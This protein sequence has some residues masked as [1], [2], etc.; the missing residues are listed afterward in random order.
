MRHTRLLASISMLLATAACGLS[1]SEE[2]ATAPP[3]EQPG[4]TLP[5]A[6][7]LISTQGGGSPVVTVG[8]TIWWID[9]KGFVVGGPL[10]QVVFATDS[11]VPS[12]GPSTPSQ[13]KVRQAD[14]LVAAGGKL[15]LIDLTEARAYDPQ[16][17]LQNPQAEPTNTIV[18]APA[19]DDRFVYGIPAIAAVGSLWILILSNDGARQ[20]LLR[21]DPGSADVVARIAI[22]STNLGGLSD[23]LVAG[24]THVYV[25]TGSTILAVD[26]ATNTITARTNNDRLG[27]SPNDFAPPRIQ[28]AAV[29]G[30]ELLVFI[31][32]A[33]N[34]DEAHMARL[35][36]T[37]LRLVN[38]HV[39]H[40]EGAD[41]QINNPSSLNLG[42]SILIAAETGIL[43][44]PL[45]LHLRNEQVDLEPFVPPGRVPAM[46]QNMSGPE[47][48]SASNDVVWSVDGNSGIWAID[49]VRAPIN[50]VPWTEGSEA[51]PEADHI[52]D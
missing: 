14:T 26:S 41:L 36:L 24:P 3:P 7:T 9:E 31:T 47:F 40:F 51:C 22:D 6:M 27:K 10:D 18:L 23:R 21:I 35:N 46:C 2:D 37:D 49:P 29:A 19:A 45:P 15:W 1:S 28:D 52:G 44:L 48:L 8:N 17:L 30:D 38:Q 16:S 12:V 11:V 25:V 42:N 4:I 33:S 50:S 20:E 32:P 34:I 5:A 39:V 43:K 13:V